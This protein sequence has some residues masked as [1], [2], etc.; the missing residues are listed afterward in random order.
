MILNS[1]IGS[2]V[3]FIFFFI[4]IFLTSESYENRQ[5]AKSLINDDFVIVLQDTE[6]TCVHPEFLFKESIGV[7]AVG[8][9]HPFFEHA[10]VNLSSQR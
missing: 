9:F 3:Y 2:S 8:N 5:K 4:D 10:L 6:R 1:L 7:L